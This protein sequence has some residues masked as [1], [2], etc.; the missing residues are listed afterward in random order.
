MRLFD[1]GQMKQE[2]EALQYQKMALE[3]E[4]EYSLREQK[5][6]FRLSQKNL[7][8]I[9]LKLK[10]AG[11][12]LKAA[13]ST[14]KAIVKK[15]ENGLVDNIAYL[16]ALNNQTLAKA[17]YDETRYEYEIAKSIYYYYAG[18]DPEEFIQ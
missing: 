11:S 1:H 5:M 7:K 2:R 9:R 4:R 18:K 12:E 10:S 15:F 8:T 16:D 13:R 14:Y 17:R 6:Q 3:A